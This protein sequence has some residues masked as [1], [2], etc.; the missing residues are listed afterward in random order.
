MPRPLLLLTFALALLAGAI[1]CRNE[2]A[3]PPESE[4]DKSGQARKPHPHP[5][6]HKNGDHEHEPGIHGGFIVEV[7][8]DNYHAEFV[9][10]KMGVLRVFT[11]GK[12]ETRVQEV[13]HQKV[14]LLVQ[15][16][17]AEPVE[18]AL[19]PEPQSSDAKDKTSRFAGKLPKE[20]WDKELTIRSPSGITI[21]GERFRINAFK[22]PPPAKPT[23]GGTQKERDLFLK[24][25]GLY[26]A[27]DIRRNGNT[28]PSVKF[29]DMQ[30]PHD[31]K[32]EAG[33]RVC[34]ITKNK[35]DPRCQWVVGG[36]EYTFCCPPCLTRFVQTAKTDPSKIKA[37]EEY[38]KK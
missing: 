37:P 34:P 30:W 26:T 22:L 6:P 38:I 15:H 10:A 33:D 14:T 16:Q 7:G 1:G 9:P 27:E 13:E 23:A 19:E 32:F 28:V 3:A 17:D 8:R 29:K 36:K 12:D 4:R 21:G 18:V 35:A 20:L 11:L 24:P 5:H 25:E 2:P 31:D